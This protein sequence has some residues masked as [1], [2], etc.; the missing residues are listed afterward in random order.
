MAS[1]FEAAAAWIVEGIADGEICKDV[2]PASF[3]E[4]FYASLLG[5][6]YQWLVNPAIDLSNSFEVLKNNIVA[7]YGQNPSEKEEK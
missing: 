1:P 4:Q 5:L 7:L 2:D 3:G 6:N